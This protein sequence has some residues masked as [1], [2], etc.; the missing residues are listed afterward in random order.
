ME[1][2]GAV[3]CTPA[4]FDPAGVCTFGIETFREGRLREELLPTECVV[5]VG[6]KTVLGGIAEVE[7]VN[8]PTSEDGTE[9]EVGV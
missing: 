7:G 6:K 2:A 4:P 1:G 5:F 3:V 9:D 8:A